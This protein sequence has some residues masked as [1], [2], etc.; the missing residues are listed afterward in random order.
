MTNDFDL[1]SRLNNIMHNNEITYACPACG[2]LHNIN[3]IRIHRS[4]LP[5]TNSNLFKMMVCS[6]CECEWIPKIIEE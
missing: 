6:M 1:D 4:K 3:D 2:A 5:K